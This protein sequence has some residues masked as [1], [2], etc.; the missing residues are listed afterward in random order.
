[1]FVKLN[2]NLFITI[3]SIFL[4][5]CSD[6]EPVFDKIF[7]DQKIALNLSASNKDVNE[8]SSV[9]VP[10]SITD[11]L[12]YDV[13]VNW[14]II[15]DNPATYFGTTSGT[16]SYSMLDTGKTISLTTLDTGSYE[17]D[18]DYTL[19]FTLNH[20]EYE[21]S[22][23]TMG[24]NIR[25]KDDEGA[26]VVSLSGTT[27]TVNED[28]GNVSIT[29]NMSA[30]V[31]FPVTVQYQIL[32][33][34]TVDSNDH[35][36]GTSFTIPA[37][38]SSYSWSVPITDDF[39]PENL[40]TL[41]LQIVSATGNGNALSIDGSNNTYAININT[42]DS[43]PA[44]PT[45]LTLSKVGSAA[46]TT[47]SQTVDLTIAA[48][49]ASKYCLTE[50]LISR[51]ASGLADCTNGFG[52]N[53]GWFT[54]LPSS[55]TLSA[56]DGL[57]TVYLW[58]ADSNN[59]VSNNSVN[60]TITLDTVVP[61]LTI[62]SPATGTSITAVNY[63]SFAISGSCS[64]N[65]RNV[66]FTAT[67][68]DS[69]NVICSSGTYTVNV[70]FSTAV[71]GIVSVTLS[72]NDAAGNN[73]NVSR[74]FTRA[75][76]V[77]SPSI[78]VK[79]TSSGNSTFTNDPN[80]SISITNEA[81]IDKWCVSE[82]QTSQPANT[83]TCSGSSWVSS[84]PTT[85]S[86][87][88][89]DG[90]KTVYVWVAAGSLINPSSGSNTITLDTTI[91]SLTYTGSTTID[92]S[93]YQSFTLS[94]TCSESGQSV[95]LSGAVGT[96]IICSSNTWSHIADFS[97]LADGPITVYADM[98]DA[99]GNAAI[100]YTINLT[101]SVQSA[102]PSSI[103]LSDPAANTGYAI[104]KTIQVTIADDPSATQWCLS[105]TQTS[106]PASTAICD[107]SGWLTTEPTNF[108]LADTGDGLRTVY[109]WT[110]DS[111]NIVSA[112]SVNA[113]ITLD[114]TPPTLSTDLS[115]NDDIVY[116]NYKNF[117]IS[118]NCSENGQT[119][120]VTINSGAITTSASC[121]SNTYSVAVDFLA[122]LSYPLPT[123]TVAIDMKDSAG[124]SAP[125]QIV[126]L[127]FLV[128]F[129]DPGISLSVADA[130]PAS[131]GYALD[132]T[133]DSVSISNDGSVSKWCLS[134]G[135]ISRPTSISAGTCNGAN[136]SLSR[137]TNL[138]ISSG[139]GVK[140]IY[141]WVADSDGAINAS[142]ISTTI[143]LDTSNPSIPSTLTLGAVTAD[144]TET[145]IMNWTASS[146][147]NGIAHY[148]VQ[149][150]KNSDGTTI[151]SWSTLTSGSKITG[152]S[153]PLD[154]GTNYT[155][156][157]RAFDNAGNKSTA[158]TNFW[159]TPT[160]APILTLSPATLSFTNEAEEHTI[161]LSNDG[162]ATTGNLQLP[163]IKGFNPDNFTITA[164]NCSGGPL[165]VS[166]SCNFN[167]KF[168]ASYSDTFKASL[169]IGDGTVESSVVNI[170]ADHISSFNEKEKFI[171]VVSGLNH[172]CGLTTDGKAYCWGNSTNGALGIGSSSGIMQI[173][174]AVELNGVSNAQ[175][176]KLSAGESFTCGL[177]ASGTVYCWGLNNN[178][179]LGINNS[180]NQ[181]S[182]DNPVSGLIQTEVFIQI[183][184]SQSHTC[185][186]TN[187][188]KVWCWGSGTNHKLGNGSTSNALI[189]TE[190]NFSSF[191][192]SDDSKIIKVAAT[193][194]ASC[195][196]AITGKIFCWGTDIDGV[197]GYASGSA[198]TQITTPNS[199]SAVDFSGVSNEKI[200]NMFSGYK[201]VCALN[202]MGMLS[203]WGANDYDQVNVVGGGAA[204]VESPV[205]IDNS[206]FSNSQ[207]NNV[208][209]GLNSICGTTV[210][211]KLY[212][213]GNNING[214]IDSASA[215]TN[216]PPKPISDSLDIEEKSFSLTSVSNEN[217]CVL[218]KKGKVFCW[219][220]DS[221][222]L[223][224]NNGVAANVN[225]MFQSIDLKNISATSNSIKFIKLYASQSAATTTVGRVCG[226]TS[227]GE[228]YCWGNNQNGTLGTGD[229]IQQN[230]PAKVNTSNLAI[231]ESFIQLSLQP[232][233]TC[234]VTN[235]GK[236]YCWGDNEQFVFGLED[237]SNSLVPIEK[238][239]DFLSANELIIKVSGGE[240]HNCVLTSLANVF[241]W[242]SQARG[243]IGDGVNGSGITIGE[244]NIN[245][246]VGN[247]RI[248]D[249]ITYDSANCIITE[250]NE[251]WCWGNN[252]YGKLGVGQAAGNIV[253]NPVKISNFNFKKLSM[254]YH[255]TCGIS[256]D[257]KVYC[258]GSSASG[259]FGTTTSTNHNTPQLLLVL[260]GK[261]VKDIYPFGNS[262][263]VMNGDSKLKC[264]GNNNVK[265]L[266]DNNVTD[267]TI[268]DINNATFPGFVFN[269]ITTGYNFVCY[270]DSNSNSKCWG[271]ELN[272]AFGDGS[273]NDG[274]HGIHIPIDTNPIQ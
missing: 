16:V 24:V 145:P 225:D 110:A 252:L 200:I 69:G 247:V 32:N 273:D 128:D 31:N 190:V 84:I 104:G 130:A 155:A 253:A 178:G 227:K 269:N 185:G 132:T 116:A 61:N 218:N 38:S 18:R 83:T 86:L 180:T 220:D 111:S 4:I 94:G 137:P 169:S 47:N 230:S 191:G 129:P 272:G 160:L 89:G 25:L 64:E 127:D 235:L 231:N 223:N 175:L 97:A 51:P 42:N 35:A 139:D 21:I 243:A 138:N 93:N 134:D 183:S 23:S 5:S 146:D 172:R 125:S 266:G 234:G 152:I 66:S 40:E 157:I 100:Q 123:I 177:T 50:S 237:N 274:T 256:I 30:M 22:S 193:N 258:M 88:G 226:L 60:G 248:K 34:S 142:A 117:S 188:M 209:I 268:T 136:W 74:N 255:H 198:G 8:N 219:G 106:R 148:E 41:N 13:E 203:C 28:V 73:K 79:D 39:T 206:N 271:N 80:V 135:Q 81:A 95:V 15:G 140:T 71:N 186:V 250:T 11:H 212:C 109:I 260:D 149:I 57:K 37:N 29:V 233:Y 202:T 141:L 101:K 133:I 205:L 12:D 85:F 78:L 58:I 67:G 262:T 7:K 10:F 174:T 105:E 75:V 168:N 173:P 17:G 112:A 120:D 251:A 182:L 68:G 171:E 91:P 52:S 27:T 232:T 165:A 154:E 19:Q 119:V 167:V 87:S 77:S 103:S 90:L 246:K 118:G 224:G 14:E 70:D 156:H 184:S 158:T 54:S 270:I 166:A 196:L 102:S 265:Q 195:A 213:W 159:T 6:G 126:N 143:T 9:D 216:T 63:S 207:I 114:E 113:T 192:A 221:N 122:L 261:G 43:A 150:T 211:S 48:S 45:S 131:A 96:S 65:S 249:I 259:A 229:Q 189:A 201:T 241:C 144:L 236:M 62:S 181:N 124:N 36:L 55:I 121:S 26:P 147:A 245:A 108:T 76:F 44:D 46:G 3:M 164:D 59:I 176:I 263:C 187:F 107:G 199:A 92:I 163:V 53:N 72:Q 98:E 239:R 153:P 242:G 208:S 217:Y 1:M 56:G 228:A 194:N 33:S 267:P 204:R 179:Q 197:L 238:N 2:F 222:G 162:N 210:E 82:S 257:D 99:A 264:F 161:T 254:G 49:G 115:N 151:H 244:F 215:G 214:Y 170:D 20:S 240:Y